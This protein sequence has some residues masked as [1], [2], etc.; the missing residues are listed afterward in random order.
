MNEINPTN[1]NNI[2][3]RGTEKMTTTDF[4]QDIQNAISKLYTRAE[5]EVAEYG[6]FADV[7][8]QFK[9]SNENLSATDFELKI[10]KPETIKDE[11]YRCFEAIAYSYPK[12]YKAEMPL[13]Q[14]SKEEILQ[15]LKNENLPKELE[16][17]FTQLSHDL[18]DI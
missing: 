13:Y 12:P 6:S 15:A 3:P 8:E 1:F 4:K 16:D 7:K 9:N 17:A 10:Y 5:R 14:G 2:Q 18:E 11:K